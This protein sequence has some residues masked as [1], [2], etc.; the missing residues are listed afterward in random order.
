VD[1]HINRNGQSLGPFSYEETRQRLAAGEFQITDLAWTEGQPEWMPLSSLP[2]FAPAD[3]T[4]LSNQPIAAAA[5]PIRPQARAGIAARVPVS[6]ATSPAQ[7]SSGLYPASASHQ[8]NTM[9][10]RLKH[11]A[12]LQ[13]GIVLGTLY[14]AISLIFL[15]IVILISIVGAKSQ[16]GGGFLAGGLLFIIFIPVIYGILGFIGGVISGA[17][18][19]LIAK[20]TGGIEFTLAD[21]P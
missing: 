4:S 9:T 11:I 16:N 12:P 10:K 14:A 17:V 2:G 8:T 18:Y 13:L 15:P 19:N 1:I 21:V 5:V 3:V 20:W 7:P 6:V